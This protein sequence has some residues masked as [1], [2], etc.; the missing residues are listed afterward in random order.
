MTAATWSERSVVKDVASV[1]DSALPSC[2]LRSVEGYFRT[3]DL[4]DLKPYF[5]LDEGQPLTR[6][7][8]YIAPR[9]TIV[10]IESPKLPGVNLLPLFGEDD[11]R[12][13]CHDILTGDE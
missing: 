8:P 9:V 13:F 4:E 7:Q 12:H 2:R 3:I 11:L 5:H 10:R 6:D 1:F